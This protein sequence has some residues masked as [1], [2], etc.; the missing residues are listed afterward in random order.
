LAFR[1]LQRIRIAP[2]FTLNLGKR[3]VSVSAGVRGARVTFG[4]RGTRATVGLP[5][6]GLSYSTPLNGRAADLGVDAAAA[7]A[8]PARPLS[9]ASIAGWVAFTVLLCAGAAVVATVSLDDPAPVAP[10]ATAAPTAPEPIAPASTTAPDTAATARV[11][12]GDTLDLGGQRVRL[13]GIDAPEL[14]QTCSGK[15]GQTYM[16]GRDATAVL[17]ELTRRRAVQCEK[18]DQDRYGRTVSV[19]RTEAGEINAAMVRRGW[20]VDYTQYSKG[21]YKAEE[22]AAKAD[23]L[24]IWSGRFDMPADWRTQRR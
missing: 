21:R 16:C 17:A 22:A 18:R 6:T 3:G 9:A 12:D 8:A 1:F 19:C 10:V 13:W 14:R 23:K 15:D 24:G 4:G 11:V 7:P 20:A 2:G 5:G